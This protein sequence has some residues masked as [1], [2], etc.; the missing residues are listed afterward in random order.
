MQDGWL[1]TG[2][3]GWFDGDGYLHFVDRSKDVIKR[4]GDNIA[5]GEV[6]RVLGE[7][8]AVVVL[9]FA[10][11]DARLAEWCARSLARFMV[12]TLFDFREAL[13]KTS[14]EKIMKYQLRAD[15][16]AQNPMR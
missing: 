14:I 7:H 11:T 4:A 1:I 8:P 3:N 6:E 15:H 10:V 13:P 9:R 12:P 16:L 2:D 5:A